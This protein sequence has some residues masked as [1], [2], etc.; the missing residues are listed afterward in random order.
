MASAL[1]WLSHFILIL[2]RATVFVS[3]STVYVGSLSSLFYLEVN[4]FVFV[5]CVNVSYVRSS[6]EPNSYKEIGNTHTDI[7]FLK[8]VYSSEL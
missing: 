3:D 5:V 6:K 1:F 4:K 2:S 7:C 8:H